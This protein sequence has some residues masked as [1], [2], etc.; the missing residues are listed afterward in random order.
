MIYFLAFVLRHTL[1]ESG[2]LNLKIVDSRNWSKR[3]LMAKSNFTFEKRQKELAKK[4]DEK[5]L[6]KLDQ[7]VEEPQ[8]KQPLFSELP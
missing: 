4:K 5:R 2:L 3:V 8:T 1:I 7:G 6:K